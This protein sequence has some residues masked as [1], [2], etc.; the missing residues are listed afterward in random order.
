[1]KGR[2]SRC[3]ML[4][5]CACQNLV[6]F[7]SL[8]QLYSHLLSKLRQIKNY[9]HDKNKDSYLS[10]NIY[11][12]SNI[13]THQKNSLNNQCQSRMVLSLDSLHKSPFSSTPNTMTL[14]PWPLNTLIDP[15]ESI[16]HT[17]IP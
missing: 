7:I 5:C 11:L 2:S 17:L 4:C 10:L 13:Y 14:A 6:G 16:L 15:G 8:S 3:L 1:M 12:Q 9:N